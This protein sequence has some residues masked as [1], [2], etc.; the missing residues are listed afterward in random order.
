MKLVIAL[1]LID[2]ILLQRQLSAAVIKS[3][4]NSAQRDD[5]LFPVS[6]IHINDFHARF[7]E[8]NEIAA[9]CKEGEKCIGGLARAV[10]VIKEL[11]EARQHL[12]PIY[13]NAGDNFQGTP[14]YTFGRWNI[15]A[16]AL[17]LQKA[18]AITIGNHE[19][20]DGIA[21]LIP[22]METVE[23]PVVVANIDD[24][25][26]MS[27]HDKY[28]KS[29]VIDRY[30]RKIGII[31]VILETVDQIANTGRLRFL[32]ESAAIKREAAALKQQGV[33]IVIVLS[34]C[35][36][37][38]DYTIARETG[39]Y[40]DVIV[41]GHSHTFMYTS[42]NG[43]S[44]PGP[45]TVRDNYPAVVE[46]EDGH[47]VLIVQASAFLKYVGDLT[48]Y[49]DK[50]GRV[51]SWEGAPIFLDSDIVPDRDVVQALQPWK[52][53]INAKGSQAIGITDVPL[54]KV[55]CH[56]QE[57]PLGNLITDAFAQYAS[58]QE[59]STV[60][61]IALLPCGSIHTSFNIGEITYNDLRML[62]PFENTI[63]TFEL[64]GDHLKQLFEHAVEESWR[65]DE[66][67]GKWLVQVSGMRV[68]Y[69]MTNPVQNRVIGMDVLNSKHLYQPIELTEYYR[70]AAQSFMTNGG[71]NFNMIL[72]NRR[73]LHRGSDDITA[74]IQYFSTHQTI[75]PALEHRLT[76]LNWRRRKKT[77]FTQNRARKII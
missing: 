47:R 33:D 50:D 42:R 48:V 11:M 68:T 32:N 36:L 61:T 40:V 4:L 27:I 2:L 5:E 21:G 24:S 18:D 70:C 39:A 51:V 12:N 15:T 52:E 7:E 16:E 77:P 9:A 25:D 28:N 35:G 38:A 20:D 72:N 26:E 8:T 3:K 13:L 54:L 6:I 14:W 1:F 53:R 63:D 23:S 69:N 49:F 19:F 22:F 66:F 43:E 10:T 30:D 34:H 65:P 55:P 56:S 73:N 44:A 57:C 46:H 31:G 37:D 45:D 41:G 60:S 71:D 62:F 58:A 29:I 17:N 67:I 74:I 64:R 59:K 75:H 76:L